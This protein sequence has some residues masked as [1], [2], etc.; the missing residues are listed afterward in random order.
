MTIAFLFS[1]IALQAGLDAPFNKPE[2]AGAMVS[3]MVADALGQP[4]AE[5]NSAIRMVPASNQKLLTAAFALHRLGPD[6][7]PRTRI[8]KSS[9]RTI[10]DSPGDPMMTT[11]R[12]RQ[13]HERLDLDIRNPVF[14]RQAYR[15]YWPDSWEIDDLPFSYAA[16]V[17]AFTVDRGRVELW[18]VDGR[19]RFE[20]DSF[21]LRL[22][23]R[24][25]PG[26]PVVRYDPF[27][28][29]VNVS[30]TLPKTRTRLERLSLPRPDEAAASLLGR[31]MIAI[32][33]IPEGPPSAI[34]EGNPIS[35][36]LGACLVPSDNNIAEHLM[37]MASEPKNVREP[38]LEARQ[39]MST[40]LT[41]TV[42][43]PAGDIRVNDGSGLS[44]HNIVTTR[45]LV[46]LLAWADRQGSRE[47][48]RKSL[49]RPTTGTLGSRLSGLSFEG[50]TGTLD[51]VTAL[52][53][54]VTTSSGDSRI[55]SVILNHYAGSAAAARS[56]MDDFVR[57]V[58]GAP[59][60]AHF[61][62]FSGPW[63]LEA[64]WTDSF[65]GGTNPERRKAVR[66][67]VSGS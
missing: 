5:R 63:N 58:A 60:S 34:L 64:F 53:G 26:T 40:F 27:R 67:Q 39:A 11:A 32:D 36:V 9:D 1:A 65:R 12:L 48:W 57:I 16:P 37:L 29:D 31:R 55:V 20:P 38:Y 19:A 24:T 30:G 28:R 8:W 50:K 13:A 46:Q 54:Y 21:G 6:Y 35:E 43:L 22:T 41:S 45:S 23:V 61:V 62:P 2:F 42:G 25:M 14:V 3:Y 10:V 52:S 47:L 7:R 49:V 4:I 56:A 18:A 17:T 51:M 59:G 44:R 33:R 15:P 66:E